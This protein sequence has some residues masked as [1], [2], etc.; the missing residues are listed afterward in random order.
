MP[1]G[2]SAEAAKYLLRDITPKWKGFWLHMHLTAF[3]LSEFAAALPEISDEVFT[4]HVSGQKNDFSRWLREVVGDSEL[5][6]VL[7]GVKNKEDAARI[8]RLRVEDLRRQ[9][10]G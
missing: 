3:S 7:D 4:Y 2:Q 5:A 1:N 10:G 6:Q 9:V 8:V